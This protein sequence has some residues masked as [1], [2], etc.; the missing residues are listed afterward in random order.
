MESLR[1]RIGGLGAPG[2]LGPLAGHVDAVT[3][4]MVSGWARDAANPRHAVEIEIM[5]AGR[6]L[7]RVVANWWRPD[8]AAAGHGTGHHGFGFVPPACV[9]PAGITRCRAADGAPSSP[10]RFGT[11]PPGSA[12]VAFPPAAN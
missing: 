4:G 2:P 12:A 5:A 10:Q 7:G 9:S 1:R 11:L 3:A 8:L 6:P